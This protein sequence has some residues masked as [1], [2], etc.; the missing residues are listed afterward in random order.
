VEHALDSPY[1]PEQQ[2]FVVRHGIQSVLGIGGLL[3][4]GELFAV[5][6]FATVPVPAS[7]AERFKALALDVK[8]AFS[9]FNDASVFNRPTLPANY[10]ARA[11]QG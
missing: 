4:T 8:S 9:R 6:L 5:I 3:P 11:Q 7:T 1:I 10:E 2:E